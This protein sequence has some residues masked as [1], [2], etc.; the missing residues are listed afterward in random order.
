MS[1]EKEFP[2]T[3]K[4][5][6]EKGLFLPGNK[7]NPTG[8]GGF[9]ENPQNINPGG[10]TK[11]QQSFSY[12]MNYFKNLTNEEFKAWGKLP[13]GSKYV[14]A[15]LAYERVKNSQKEIQEFKEVADRTE[16]KAPQTITHKGG[17][18]STDKIEVVEVSNDIQEKQETNPDI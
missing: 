13:D 17:F 4:D 7:A 6:D 8:K 2:A 10:R 5:R 14:A 11:N 12:W 18:F 1:E 15:S 3:N 16:G 9:S